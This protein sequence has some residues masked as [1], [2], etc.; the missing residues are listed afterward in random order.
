MMSH[1]RGAEGA[2]SQG[3]TWMRCMA[4]E[5]VSWFHLLMGWYWPFL[6][7]RS[8]LFTFGLMC[9][10]YSCSQDARHRMPNQDPAYL[11]FIENRSSLFTSGLMC[12]RYSYSQGARHSTLN[13]GPAYLG[14]A[15]SHSPCPVRT[16]SGG[17]PDL[18]SRQHTRSHTR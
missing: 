17:F 10:R 18:A 5:L 4:P 16:L 3:G 6:V 12:C 2:L 14:S 7:N 9:C 1:H 11:P 15:E 13:Q 8:S